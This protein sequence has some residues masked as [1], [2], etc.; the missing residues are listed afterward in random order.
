VTLSHDLSSADRDRLQAGVQLSDGPSRL[1]V[2]KTHGPEARV[3]LSE[4]RNRQVRRT[5]GALGYSVVRLHRI[6]I[7]SY[8]LGD[9]PEGA[10]QEIQPA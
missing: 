8:P 5:F 10:W 3:S 6:Q 9:L 7:G 4:G 1:T 2:M